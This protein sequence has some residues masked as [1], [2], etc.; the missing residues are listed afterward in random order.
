MR[1]K[2]RMKELMII[3]KILDDLN[4]KHYFEFITSSNKQKKA[5]FSDVF[6][7]IIQNMHKSEENINKLIKS[8]KRIEQADLD[9]YDIDDILQSLQEIFGAGIPNV[10]TDLIN[11]TE[12][13]KKWEEIKISI[14]TMTQEFLKKDIKILIKEKE[15]E[16]NS[17]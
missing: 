10:I 15:K 14:K 11:I 7:F 8:Y 5:G 1:T 6:V 2:L 16:K 12:L 13:K 3:S 4:F 9:N 17:N